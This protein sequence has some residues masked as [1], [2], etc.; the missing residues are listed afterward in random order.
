MTHEPE[1][2]EPDLPRTAK[3]RIDEALVNSAALAG[4][5]VVLSLT[6]AKTVEFITAPALSSEMLPTLR[7]SAPLT[8]PTSNVKTEF[9]LPGVRIDLE[10]VTATLSPSTS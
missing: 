9:T 1:L 6:P 10:N 4:S 5:P 8:E 2:R 3:V 7:T